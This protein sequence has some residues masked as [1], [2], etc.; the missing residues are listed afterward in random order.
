MD[1]LL[2]TSIYFG[3]LNS[4]VHLS[5]ADDGILILAVLLKSPALDF[6]GAAFLSRLDDGAGVLVGCGGL[7][8][9]VFAIAS[10][11]ADGLIIA[12]LVDDSSTVSLCKI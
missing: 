10:T 9:G 7:L 6:G 11:C 2:P 8:K 12:H 3:F 1:D 4:V 5:L